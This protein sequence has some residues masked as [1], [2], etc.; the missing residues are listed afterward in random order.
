MKSAKT[1]PKIPRGRP[2][3]KTTA[4]ETNQATSVEFEREGLGVAPTE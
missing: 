1:K 2:G 4:G 3:K